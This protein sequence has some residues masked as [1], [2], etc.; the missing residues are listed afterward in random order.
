M[1]GEMG[2]LENE[3]RK[4][5]KGHQNKPVSPLSGSVAPSCDGGLSDLCLLIIDFKFNFQHPS[6]PTFSNPC[7]PP[8]P[9]P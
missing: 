1:F 8:S 9:P 4:G 3:R 2:R 7:S 5:R 6:D